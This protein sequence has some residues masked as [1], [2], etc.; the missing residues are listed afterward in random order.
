MAIVASGDR[1]PGLAAVA[2]PTLVIHGSA[3]PLVPLSGGEATVRA[4]PG[5][6]LLVIDDMGHELPPAVWPQVIRAVVANAR[7]AAPDEGHSPGPTAA[8]PSGGRAGS[9]TS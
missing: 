8:I 7:R 2:V 9:R 1:T 6:E 4:I 3:D 5:A